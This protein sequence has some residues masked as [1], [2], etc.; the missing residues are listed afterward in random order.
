MTRFF[1]DI[2]FIDQPFRWLD[3]LSLFIISNLAPHRQGA[4]QITCVGLD[5]SKD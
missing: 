2:R 4:I 5:V 3:Q 1:Q